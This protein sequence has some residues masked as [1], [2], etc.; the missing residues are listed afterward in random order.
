ML[1]LEE[2]EQFVAFVDNGTLSRAAEIL[3]ISQP[4]LTRTM[5]HVEEAFGTS[6][7]V[8]GKNRIALNEV[9]LKAAEV[10]RHLLNQAANAIQ[11]V[12]VLAKSLQTI[13]IETCAPV[14]LWVLLSSLAA[15]YPENTISSKIVSIDKVVA[16]VVSGACDIGILPF[17]KNDEHFYCWPFMQENLSV[18]IPKGHT[19][20]IAKTLQLS[21]LNGFNCL[22]R[23]QI[24]FWTELCRQK[25]PAS[26]FLVQTN[27]FELK[28]LIK[29]STLLCFVTDVVKPSP[30]IYHDR[31]IVPISDPEANVTYHI[32]SRPH[33]PELIAFLQLTAQR[34][35]Q[36]NNEQISFFNN[37]ANCSKRKER[38][39]ER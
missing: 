7:F 38:L 8:R 27:D 1:N 20:S 2:L 30:E 19:L 31:A 33:K 15:E 29:T 28:E 21:D 24:G 39:A 11:E 16:D 6:L 36:A 25:M 4:T 35:Y 3:H 18:C 10:A 14:P 26:R 22:L 9:G 12:Q 32:I 13:S 37:I 23:G 34:Q 5:R 17:A